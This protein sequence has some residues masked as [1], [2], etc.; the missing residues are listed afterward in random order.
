MRVQLTLRTLH[1]L[2]SGAGL[3]REWLKA[4]MAIRV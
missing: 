2:G 1:S 3:G 4:A